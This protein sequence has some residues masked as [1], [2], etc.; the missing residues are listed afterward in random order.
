[1]I[2]SINSLVHTQQ[3]KINLSIWA[4]DV[5]YAY[6]LV[7]TINILDLSVICVP[8]QHT[9]ITGQEWASIHAWTLY[10]LTHIF[11]PLHT[12]RQ[13]ATSTFADVAHVCFSLFTLAAQNS[14]HP[15][16]WAD[17]LTIIYVTIAS[18]QPIRM[19]A[20]ALSHALTSCARVLRT[21][22]RSMAWCGMDVCNHLTL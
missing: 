17:V 15:V 19:Y 4:P 5:C 6:K 11:N 1:V 12:Y 16:A 13:N 8:A 9:L 22:N 18:D 7:A 21:A 14:S 10:Q 2:D 20:S 3:S